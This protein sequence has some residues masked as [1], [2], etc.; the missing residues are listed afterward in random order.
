[1][2]EGTMNNSDLVNRIAALEQLMSA[3]LNHNLA[4]PPFSD[5]SELLPYS[6]LEDDWSRLINLL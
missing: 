1:M 3:V 5:T 4:L 6:E 2:F